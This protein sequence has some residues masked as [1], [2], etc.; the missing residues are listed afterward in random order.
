MTSE[1]GKM[2]ARKGTMEANTAKMVEQSTAFFEAQTCP[3]PLSC[4]IAKDKMLSW[5]AEAPGKRLKCIAIAEDPLPR[6]NCQ[7]EKLENKEEKS[8]EDWKEGKYSLVM[9]DKKT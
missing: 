5:T 6:A 9:I 1:Q 4:K 2:D 3:K 8:K 7:Y